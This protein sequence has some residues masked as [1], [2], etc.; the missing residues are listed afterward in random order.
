[1]KKFLVLQV[2]VTIAAF[3]TRKEAESHM[4]NLRVAGE[5]HLQVYNYDSE[6]KMLSFA[7]QAKQRYIESLWRI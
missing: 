2:N 3:D 4:Y 5:K 7:E 6:A 1:M